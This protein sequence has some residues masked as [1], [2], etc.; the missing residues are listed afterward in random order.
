MLFSD[1]LRLRPGTCVKRLGE[2]M[3][4]MV[5]ERSAD[6]SCIAV[7]VLVDASTRPQV[8][9]QETYMFYELEGF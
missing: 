3:P 8:I 7:P 2:Y 9:T 1:Y 6:G 5:T 4:F